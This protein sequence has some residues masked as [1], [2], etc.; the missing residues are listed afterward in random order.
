M[1][2]PRPSF[3]FP[4]FSPRVYF[5]ERLVVRRQLI[6][7][8]RG[9]GQREHH[10]RDQ[11]CWVSAAPRCGQHTCCS[12]A[13]LV[14]HK[15]SCGTEQTGP[16]RIHQQSGYNGRCVQRWEMLRTHTHYPL[17]SGQVLVNHKYP[18]GYRDSQSGRD[19]QS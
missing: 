9:S 8:T 18:H 7:V 19:P 15:P 5:Q 1:I 17:G 6:K 16:A 13:H 10:R 2:Q 4:N 3:L 14:G 11:C 12:E